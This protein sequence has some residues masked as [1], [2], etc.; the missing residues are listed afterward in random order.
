M[1]ASKIK[2]LALSALIGVLVTMSLRI[3]LL[4]SQLDAKEHA[5]SAKTLQLSISEQANKRQAIALQTQIDD[6]VAAMQR[7]T[8]R[9]IRDH[10]T[11]KELQR[12]IAL[13]KTALAKK[14]CL[15]VPY[16][17]AVINKLQQSY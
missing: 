1:I 14:E 13:F 3:R 5:L 7:L 6:Q 11:K 15:T 10:Q 4:N 2:I 8:D 9:Q 17:P 12:D 16:P